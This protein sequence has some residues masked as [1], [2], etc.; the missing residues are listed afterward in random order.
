[1]GDEQTVYPRSRGIDRMILTVIH[2][3]HPTLRR[4]GARI[5]R[6]T[7]EIAQ[8]AQDMIETMYAAK[9]IGLAAQQVNQALQLM[10]VDVRAVSDRP[11][12]LAF[13][14]QAVEAG[15]H[16]PMVLI[17]PELKPL[18]LP[19]PGPEG[20]LSFPEIYADVTRPD[21]VEVGALNAQG[22]PVQFRCGGLLARVIQHEWDHLQGI[23]FIDRM[24]LKSREDL[25]P[26]LDDL[27][28]E[29]RASLAR[30]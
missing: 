27:A 30:A 29:T 6:V 28:M 11:T 1:V 9:G 20:C 15:A 24:G 16:M 14:G 18:G 19:S 7:P 12:T 8:L 13:D 26:E 5:E 21:T 25:K 3:G 2:Y 10:V 17:N 22:Q 23:L 4:Q